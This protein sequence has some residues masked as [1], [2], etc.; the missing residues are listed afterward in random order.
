MGYVVDSWKIED[1]ADAMYKIE[2]EISEF[3]SEKIRS[4]VARFTADSQI[5]KVEA[6]LEGI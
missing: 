3:N 2:M 5:E 4:K 6:I 1:L